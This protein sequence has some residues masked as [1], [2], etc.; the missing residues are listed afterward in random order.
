[1]YGGGYV[2]SDLD[3][4]IV[5]TDKSALNDTSVDWGVNVLQIELDAPNI[6]EAING[7]FAAH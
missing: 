6:S 5:F 1:M 7:F 2:H 4:P 3:V